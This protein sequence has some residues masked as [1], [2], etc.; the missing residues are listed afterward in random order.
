MA[1]ALAHGE[2]QGAQTEILEIGERELYQAR[3]EFSM[4]SHRLDQNPLARWIARKRRSV[5]LTQDDLAKAV[6][7]SLSTLTKIETG[8]RL[9]ERVVFE[10]IRQVLHEEA[11]YIRRKERRLLEKFERHQQR[12]HR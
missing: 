9:C 3:R 8:R 7:I 2:A 4:R 5:N 6:G 12:H 1:Q 11:P 10:R